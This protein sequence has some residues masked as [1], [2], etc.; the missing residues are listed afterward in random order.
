MESAKAAKAW[1]DAVKNDVEPMSF[2][3]RL[4]GTEAG[5]Y[6]GS[7]TNTS[8]KLKLLESLSRE[9]SSAGTR[10]VKSAWA[11]PESSLCVTHGM[12]TS[13]QL[14]AQMPPPNSFRGCRTK[15][16][17]GKLSTNCFFAT[18][19]FDGRL[20]NMFCAG[21]KALAAVPASLQMQNG[22]VVTPSMLED[23]WPVEIRS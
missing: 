17:D 9:N 8:T 13:F 12:S 19:M 20:C 7:Q 10:H 11:G 23:T 6:A 16:T 14:H 1:H 5:G 21:S 18:P 2:S 3:F 22:G 4:V 15:A